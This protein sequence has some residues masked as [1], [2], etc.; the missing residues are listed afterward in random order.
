V[1]EKQE[2][3]EE[4]KSLNLKISIDK[5]V[6]NGEDKITTVVTDRGT[7]MKCR[8]TKIPSVPKL[9]LMR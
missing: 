1:K 7:K 5:N 4:I 2:K 3:L 9:P 8:E 6:T